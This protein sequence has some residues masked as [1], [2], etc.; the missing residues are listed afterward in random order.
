MVSWKK[1]GMTPS[2]TFQNE[3]QQILALLPEER[4][5]AAR[6]HQALLRKR[7]IQDADT[8]LRLAFVY[9]WGD[10]SLRSTVAWA[11][12]AGVA[13]LSD[14][15]LL[16]RLQ[17]A[18]TFLGWLLAQTLAAQLPKAHWPAFSYRV[19]LVDATAIAKPGSQGTDWRV[20]L[21]M[22]LTTQTCDFIEVTDVKGGESFTRFPAEAGDLLVADRGYANRTGIASVVEKLAQVLVR[23]APANLPLQQRDGTPFDLLDHLR[24]LQPGQTGS[25]EVQTAPDPRHDLSAMS[26]RVVAL[27]LG[28]KE[29]EAARR[30]LHQTARRKGRMVQAVTLEYAEY[31]LLF[32]TLPPDA[33]TAEHALSLY[34]FRW[35]IECGFKRLKSL[36]DLDGLQAQEA[37]LCQSYL[38]AKLIG[39]L[40]LERLANSWAS[41]PP[42][43]APRTVVTVASLDDAMV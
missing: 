17:K 28:P 29:A 23:F 31:V 27:R 30:R 2:L 34:R 4:E 21:G 22:N 9:A 18:H 24:T 20:H 26:G 1:E 13:T 6:E 25:W 39:A 35:Q 7:Q 42:W 36:L 14:V 41:F 12:Q 15:A 19:R 10:L 33:L 16:E 5:T 38:Y 32:T 37:R 43:E 40:L 3:W 11:Q 8:L